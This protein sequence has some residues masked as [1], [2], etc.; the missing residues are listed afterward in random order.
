[1]GK[2]IM[3]A[4]DSASIR[5]CVKM[6]LCDAGYGVVEAVDGQ[7]ALNK[8]QAS[9]IN[10]LITD[11]NMPNVNGIE[12]IKKVREIPAG[13]FIPTVLLTTESDGSMKE[14]G[15]AA[16]ASGWIVKP[17]NNAQLLAV[18]KKLLG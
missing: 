11:L 5:Q 13:K 4:D 7:D 6:V 18:V 9:E 16:G 8:F 12:L 10:M 17:F 15:R 14:A 3:T 1:V 2:T